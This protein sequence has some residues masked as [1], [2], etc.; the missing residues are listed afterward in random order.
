M[1]SSRRHFVGASGAGLL[2]FVVGGCKQELTPSQARKAGADL[3][4]LSASQAALVDAL[5]EQLVP[6]ATEAG[7]SHFIDQQ[8]AAAPD[9]QL[10]MVKYLGVPAPWDG[11]YRDGLAGVN[12][13][14]QANHGQDYVNLSSDLA[15]ELAAALAGGS[16]EPWQGPPAGL[17]YFVLRSD[18]IDVV[19]GT[20]AGFERLGLP[21]A[22]HIVPPDGWIA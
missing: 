6:G 16:I 11:L 18:A 21:F 4:T 20:Q 5:G 10:L 12:A 13:A 8:L 22:A 2:T 7:L 9:E 3:R 17:F 15:G 19:Y 14:A 1:G